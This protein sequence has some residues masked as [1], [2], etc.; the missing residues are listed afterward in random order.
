MGVPSLDALSGSEGKINILY[1]FH[2]TFLHSLRKI[3]RLN[4]SLIEVLSNKS[5]VSLKTI[6]SQTCFCRWWNL[7]RKKTVLFRGLCF[8]FVVP[9]LRMPAQLSRAFRSKWKTLM[10]V[11]LNSAPVSISHSFGP[12]CES[13]H[14]WKTS[15]LVVF[16]ESTASL[17]S[18]PTHRQFLLSFSGNMNVVWLFAFCFFHGLIMVGFVTHRWNAFWYYNEIPFYGLYPSKGVASNT[19]LIQELFKKRSSPVRRLFVGGPQGHL[20]NGLQ[21]VTTDPVECQQWQGGSGCLQTR[22]GVAETFIDRHR[23]RGC[24]TITTTADYYAHC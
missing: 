14:E 1:E 17:S 23:W 21:E 4:E 22:V 5:T 12:R 3:H 18:N 24:E 13:S 10:L 8:F 6:P 2:E 7:I 9:R 20:I 19:S 16:K 15:P 11:R